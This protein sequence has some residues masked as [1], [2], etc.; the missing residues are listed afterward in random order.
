MINKF[1]NQIIHLGFYNIIL[2]AFVLILIHQSIAL[3]LAEVEKMHKAPVQFYWYDI[4]ITLLFI[5][6]FVY[7]IYNFRVD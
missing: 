6:V 1:I 5:F 3:L 7:G 2:Y 4:P